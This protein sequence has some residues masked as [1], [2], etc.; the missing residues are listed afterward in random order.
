MEI[1]LVSDTYK[2]YEKG[3]LLNA[4]RIVQDIIKNH[5]GNLLIFWDKS[6]KD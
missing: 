4:E 1:T 2:I 3:K 6:K 5:I